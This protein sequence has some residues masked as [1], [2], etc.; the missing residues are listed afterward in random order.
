M[1]ATR[2]AG[3]D[4]QL[5]SLTGGQAVSLAFV[6]APPSGLSRRVGAEPAG[7]SFWRIAAG[8]ETFYTQATDHFG[9]AIGAYTHGAELPDANMQEL[10]GLI[11][12]MVGL[13]YIK[14]AEVPQIPKRTTPLKFVV[15]AP[16]GKSPVAPDVVLVRGNARQLMVLSEA[17]R[18]A[19]HVQTAVTMGRPACAMV[20]YSMSSGEVVL[21]LGCIGNRVYTELSDSEGYV[22]IPGASLAST[23]DKLD[24]LVSA[25]EALE[26]FHRQRRS[27]VGT[28][29]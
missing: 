15:Y 2:L 26:G 25:N 23:M 19:G 10:S 12:K 14:E 29:I 16:L 3:W 13:S 20:P 17:G 8:G 24:A 5:H 9:C 7:C 6:D 1:D 18:A 21:S 27:D 11:G 28:R 22:A 4:R